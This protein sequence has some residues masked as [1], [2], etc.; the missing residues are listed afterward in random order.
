MNISFGAVFRTAS[1]VLAV[2][3]LMLATAAGAFETNAKQAIL[4]DVKTGVVL[5]E[6]NADEI[7]FPASMSKIMTAYLLFERLRD[8][9]L[10]LTDTLPVSETA[11]RKGGSK[12]FVEVGSQVSVEDLL[13]GI[14]VQSGNDASIAIAEGL[15]GSEGAFASQMTQRARDLGMRSTV[16]RNATGWPHPEHVTTARDLARLAGRLIADF[17][18]YYHYFREKSFTYNGIKQGN[19]NPLL[20]KELGADGL[21]TGHTDA[22]GFGLTASLMRND[23]RL[24][25]VLNGLEGAR[26]RGEEAERLAEFGFREF[27]NLD[28]FNRQE[29]VAEADVWLGD[30]PTVPLVLADDLTATMPR[31][32]R[33]DLRVSVVYNGPISAPIEQGTPIATLTVTAPGLPTVERPLL[34]GTDIGQRDFFGRITGALSYIVLGAGG[35]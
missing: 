15:A 16:Y 2:A 8:Q 33:R 23:R 21:K 28:L 25:L 31:G 34:A 32:A 10:A 18:E 30:R 19:R 13:R 3:S 4:I 5:Y 24:V 26:E 22:S 29:A 17:P 6:K 1:L 9:Q 11:W 12:M 27:E 20:F 14:V 7:M 35:S